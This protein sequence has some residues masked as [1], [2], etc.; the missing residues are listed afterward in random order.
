MIGNRVSFSWG[1]AGNLS[2]EVVGQTTINVWIV[3]LD[4]PITNPE[5][6]YCGHR[7]LAV[8]TNVL[9]PEQPVAPKV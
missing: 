6:G 2:G 8:S 5:S 4:S 9:V 3:L 1:K 7:A